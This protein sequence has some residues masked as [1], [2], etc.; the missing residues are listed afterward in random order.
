M[1]GQA[2]RMVKPG[3]SG[4]PPAA[5]QFFRSLARNNRREWFQPRKHIY[6]E[7]VKAP[8]AELIAALTS[9]MMRFAPDYVTEPGKAIYRIYRDTRFSKDKTPYKTHIAAVFPRRGLPKHG[10]AG[11]YFSVSAKEIEVAG[12]VYM[13]GP[14]ELLAIRNHLAEHHREF[15]KIIGRPKLRSLMEEMHG[16]QLARVP[17]GFPCDHPAADL[18]RYRQWLF[19]VMLDPA[20]ATTPK[21]LGEI[22]NRFEAMTPFNEFLNAP[23]VRASKQLE[24]RSLFGKIDYDPKHDYKR[25]RRIRKE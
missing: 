16:E 15:R 7:Q 1:A 9:E 14:D 5:M 22:R 21:L 12:G 10:G 4:F 19:Y 24:T 8:M 25:A 3:F 6:E 11:L 17:K 23:L 2:A 20:L 13:P 18:L